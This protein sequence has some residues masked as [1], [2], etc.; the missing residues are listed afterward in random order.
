MGHLSTAYIDILKKKKI[1]E[2]VEKI[3]H[4]SST[5]L[6][7]LINIILIIKQY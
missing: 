6:M 4:F 3:F 7:S 1:A 5:I 2:R